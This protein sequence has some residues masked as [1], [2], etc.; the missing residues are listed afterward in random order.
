MIGQTISHYKILEKLAEGGMGV[1][2]KAEDLRL[3]RLVALKFLPPD[4]TKDERAKKRFGREARAA[5]A[6]DH[7]N[8]AVVHDIGES[9]DGQS[10]ICMAYYEG[11]TV[12]QQLDRGPL[13]AK[14]ALKIAA[15]VADGLQR[16]HEAGIVHCDIKPAN[17]IVTNRGEVKILDFGV[18]R[19]GGETKSSS[20]STT[21]G[22]LAYMSPEQARGE[23]VDNRSDLFSLGVVMYEMITGR[24]PF[25]GEHDAAVLYT[26]VNCEPEPP[27][28]ID[29][30]IT[31]EMESMILRLLRKDV[32]DRYQSASKLRKAIDSILG[33][34]ESPPLAPSKFNLRIPGWKITAPLSLLIIALV[35]Y[36]LGIQPSR[37]ASTLP[38]N[39]G[40]TVIPFSVDGK[41]SAAQR[42]CNGMADILTDRLT[43]LKADCPR[44]WVISTNEVRRLPVSSATDAWLKFHTPLAIG[45]SVYRQGEMYQVF[46]NLTDSTGTQR[47][48]QEFRRALSV[49]SQLETEITATIA[50]WLNIPLSPKSKTY[51]IRGST[52]NPAAYD[53]YVRGRGYLHDFDKADN[54]TTAISLLR[55]ATIEDTLFATAYASLSRAYL[56]RFVSSKET[57]WAHAAETSADRAISLNPDVS[58]VHIARGEVLSGIYKFREATQAFQRALE[59]DPGNPSAWAGLANAYDYLDDTA[60]AVN[61]FKKAIDLDPYYWA[62][63]N[64]LGAFYEDRRRLPEALEQFRA[65]IEL[66]PGNVYAHNNIGGVLMMMGQYEK[67]REAFMRSIAVDPSE[68]AYSNLGTIDFRE[69]KWTDAALAYQFALHFAPSN[70][71]YVGHRAEALWRGKADSVLVLNTYRRAAALAE[72]LRTI[73]PNDP[74]LLYRL[75]GFYVRLDEQSL[76]RQL[77]ARTI[78]LHPADGQ[79]LVRTAMVYEELGDRKEAIELLRR[80]AKVHASLDDI[81]DSLSMKRLREDP[82][83]RNLVVKRE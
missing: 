32:A 23:T 18:V 74:A 16:A 48:S 13:D 40:I 36:L 3:R 56:R 46:V 61:A 82:A 80:A 41:D 4:F 31:P 19:L 69:K 24:R 47:E 43:R 2:Y 14:L 42:F 45:G 44:L 67:A 79:V 63:R 55:D 37:N 12:K 77:L 50:G 30:N 60:R 6:L 10:F 68:A 21:G 34:A 7:P 65:S 70:Y 28:R 78:Q 9:P 25:H 8:I 83:Y 35:V 38:K 11:R 33:P 29:P 75:A 72:S 54:V 64:A 76:A 15:Q 66:A 26:I 27:S 52:T 62:Y 81:E 49:S 71:Q 53:L 17:L 73:T 59:I 58:D 22:T 1:V 51:M 39:L 5:S 57:R 20:T